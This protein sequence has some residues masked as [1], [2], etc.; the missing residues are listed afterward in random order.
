MF[1]LDGLL[2]TVTGR[3]KVETKSPVRPGVLSGQPKNHI[4]ASEVT[5]H[6]DGSLTVKEAHT[7]STFELPAGSVKW[8]GP[9][10]RVETKEL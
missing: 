5:R 6:F 1:S 7:G 8:I 2:D 9:G 4:H 3:N 10:V